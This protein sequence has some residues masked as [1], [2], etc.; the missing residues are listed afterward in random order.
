VGVGGG[1]FLAVRQD[2]ALLFFRYNGNGE[3]DPTGTLGFE[4][5][6]E[7]NQIGNGF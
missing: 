3:Q 7:G 1:A 4:S 6:N 2:G 5:P